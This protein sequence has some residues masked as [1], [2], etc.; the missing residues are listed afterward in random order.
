MAFQKAPLATTLPDPM[1]SNYQ[2]T[3]RPTHVAPNF[4]L[5][6]LTLWRGIMQTLKPFAGMTTPDM[7][8]ANGFAV[9]NGFNVPA[10]ALHSVVSSGPAAALWGDISGIN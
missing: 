1:A 9:K 7:S 10:S 6:S 3:P 8:K 4:P 5:S 2:M